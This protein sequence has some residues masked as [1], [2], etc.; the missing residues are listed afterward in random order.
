MNSTVLYL[1][2][3]TNF[4]DAYQK[5]EFNFCLLI[6]PFFN[7]LWEFSYTS[8]ENMRRHSSLRNTYNTAISAPERE[9]TANIEESI[10]V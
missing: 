1:S 9:E 10:C 5:R 2:K 8:G 6:V 7:N 3:P 4:P